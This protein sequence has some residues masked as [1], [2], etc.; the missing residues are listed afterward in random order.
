MYSRTAPPSPY[1]LIFYIFPFISIRF[2]APFTRCPP[3][4]FEHFLFISTVFYYFTYVLY[5][6]YSKYKFFSPSYFVFCTHIL[7]SS[8]PGACAQLRQRLFHHVILV[9]FAS[10]FSLPTSPH[11]SSSSPHSYSNPTN[12]YYTSHLPVPSHYLISSSHH[13]PTLTLSRRYP[14]AHISVEWVQCEERPRWLPRAATVPFSMF[15]IIHVPEGYDIER[16]ICRNSPTSTLLYFMFGSQSACEGRMARVAWQ[17]TSMCQ[18]STC[19][20]TGYVA[21]FI[22]QGY[23]S[24]DQDL[25]TSRTALALF[26]LTM[27]PDT[28]IVCGFQSDLP[29]LHC[30]P[31]LTCRLH[32][33]C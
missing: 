6:V 10:H 32:L 29:L 9:V 12:L 31:C 24:F 23:W 3:C 30:I 1:F 17:I 4:I 14:H 13:Q 11:L 26:F 19:W 7:P 28:F 21:S 8:S 20:W 25:W 22:N 18:F 2:G 16:V 33:V 15:I 5:V 27:L